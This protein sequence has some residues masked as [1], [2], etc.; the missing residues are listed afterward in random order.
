MIVVVSDRIDGHARCVQR[1]LAEKGAECTIFDTGEVPARARISAWVDNERSARVRVR[2]EP[3]DIDFARVKTVWLRRLSGLR[4]G[5]EL[6]EEDREF[7]KEESIALLLSLG[8]TLQDRFWVNP[9]V[10]A[11]VTDRGYGKVSQLELARELGLEVPRTLATND[12]DAAR[13]FLSVTKEGAIYKPF[14]S[15]SRS[16]EEGGKKQWLVLFTTKIDWKAL[17]K[18][19]GVRHAPCIF[20]EY[21]PK[22]LELR[23]T[24]IGEK[25][26]AAEIHSQVHEKSAVDFRRHYDVE[27]TPYRIHELPRAIEEKLVALDRKLGLVFGASDL[28]H[29]P[30]GRYVFLEVQQGTGNEP[31]SGDAPHS[32]FPVE[33]PCWYSVLPLAFALVNERPLLELVAR[34][35]A[36]MLSR[37][38]SPT[39]TASASG[40]GSSRRSSSLP[41][42]APL[43][44]RAGGPRT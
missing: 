23:V 8:V 2:R 21:V 40:K 26:F 42:S 11:L 14:R 5:E 16:R 7:A 33:I 25:V 41:R 18:L 17:A 37:C 12:P 28:M 19:D 38:P 3:G 32:S 34:R 15:P 13:E 36:R 1:R 35:E 39:R 4:P 30:D 9:M 43:S 10:S 44:R 24:V 31:Q 20:Q 27:N 29:K 22:K 6:S